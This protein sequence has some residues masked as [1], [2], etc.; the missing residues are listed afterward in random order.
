MLLVDLTNEWKGVG[1]ELIRTPIEPKS[2]EEPK[3]LTV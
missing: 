1:L 3:V 2:A